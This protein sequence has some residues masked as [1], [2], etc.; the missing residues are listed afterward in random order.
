[1]VHT[2]LGEVD[3]ASLGITLMHEHLLIDRVHVSD[4]PD[5]TVLDEAL[6][7]VE[8]RAFAE[9]GG[10]TLVDLTLKS[11]GR[12]PEALA[13]ISRATGV[14]VVMGSGFYHQAFYPDA[15]ERLSVNE[16]AKS[17]TDEFEYGVDSTGIKPGIIGE[18][19]SGSFVTAQEERVFR[20][21]ARAQQI[22]GCP[23]STHAVGST[24]GAAQLD[25]LLEEGMDPGHVIVG[26]CD[27]VYDPDYHESLARRGVWVQFD[28]L[29]AKPE[30]EMMKR[31]ALVVEFARRGFGDR[32][33]L[34]QD[35]CMKSHLAAYGGHGYAGLFEQ[36]LPRLLDAG[37][38]QDV[39]DQSLTVN[40]GRVFA[41]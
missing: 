7:I 38:S 22:V 27:S 33:L 40:P 31:V 23:V 1:M 24:V 30:W 4:N 11:I 16:L 32:M 19:G 28:L 34:S 13:R 3:A 25:L 21:V 9:R 10:R 37:L 6:A 15:V 29:R 18:I 20:S 14:D 12:D 36:Y 17:I 35:V 39:F 5:H 41:G 2:V 26:H 8:L